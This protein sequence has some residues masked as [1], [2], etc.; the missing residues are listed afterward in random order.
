[1]NRSVCLNF[2][3]IMKNKLLGWEVVWVAVMRLCGKNIFSKKRTVA[4]CF[5]LLI[6]KM[7]ILVRFSGIM[8]GRLLCWPYGW[9]ALISNKHKK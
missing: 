4:A 9:G 5:V 6:G 7:Q 1:M 2:I 8:A 3:F